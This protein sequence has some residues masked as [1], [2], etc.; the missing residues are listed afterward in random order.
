MAVVHETPERTLVVA[1]AGFGV[2]LI[3]H[4]VPFHTSAS[5]TFTPE[6]LTYSP[7]ATQVAA[8]HDTPDRALLV[9]PEGVAGDW[10]DQVG[11]AAR[12]DDAPARHNANAT[13]AIAHAPG[14]RQANRSTNNSLR[15]TPLTTCRGRAFGA[16]SCQAMLRA[17]IAQTS[18]VLI[19]KPE[20]R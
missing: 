15:R 8:L 4:A 20:T 6:L 10:I 9:A 14:T 17:A 18:D 3:D 12:A 11:V 5:V 19:T 2:V 1:S 7:T 13:R 16:R